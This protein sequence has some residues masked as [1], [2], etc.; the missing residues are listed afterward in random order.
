ML[1]RLEVEPRIVLLKAGGA[2]HPGRR[3]FEAEGVKFGENP[4]S[5]IG[6]RNVAS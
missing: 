2:Q 5:G 3:D 4:R 1:T 6:L